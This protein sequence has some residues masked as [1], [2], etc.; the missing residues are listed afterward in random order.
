MNSPCLPFKPPKARKCRI[1]KSKYTPMRPM[2][3]TCGTYH[4][5]VTYADAVAAR[6]VEARAKAERQEVR[7]RKEALKPIQHFLKATERICHAYIRA[8]DAEQPCISCGT[9]D[10]LEWHAGHFIPVGRA[11]SI[12]FDEA[13][14]HKQ[15]DECNTH[16]NGNATAYEVRLTAKI[17]KEEVDRLKTAPKEKKWTRDELAAIRDKFK[18]KLKEIQ[19]GTD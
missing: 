3:P 19:H 11:K 8:R 17:G 14:I 2:Q 15:C 6:T 16:L 18:A 4:C 1:C 13:N 12:R 5:Q 10:A 7:A 9:W